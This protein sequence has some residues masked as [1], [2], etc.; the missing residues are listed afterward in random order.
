[1]PFE[2]P[3]A[4]VLG[5]GGILGEA[6]M[7]GVLA[8]LEEASGFDPR[9]CDAFV[10][11]SAGSIVAASLAGGVSPRQRLGRLP[12]QPPAPAGE[13]A[14]ERAWLAQLV[15]LATAGGG[16]AIGR[17]VPV[18][19]RWGAWGGALVRRGALARV[20]QGHRSLDGLRRAV[21]E[22]GTRF[23][24]RLLVV[25]VELESGRRV[26]FGAPDAPSAEV[27]D[28]VA[29]SCAIP[30]VFRPVE[31]GGRTYVD[32]GAWSLT[33]VDLAP[34][35]SGDRVLCLNPTG[36]TWRGPGVLAGLG[37]LSRSLAA[38]EAAVP[39]RRGASVRTV[40]PD[41]ASVEAIGASLMDPGP[42]DDVTQA[43][44]RQGLSLGLS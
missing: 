23:D 37:Q 8:G 17:L 41:A 33:N 22:T 4:L 35:R 28:A 27:A 24:G 25:A 26:A 16:A 10:G 20:P 9:G 43:G 38:V 15:R 11:T 14:A 42:R 7:S 39:R 34:V 29:A 2:L 1:V 13:H 19:L 3:D 30:G 12:E 36:S 21:R 18:A 32:G 31:I 44:F 6:W 40:T 5:A